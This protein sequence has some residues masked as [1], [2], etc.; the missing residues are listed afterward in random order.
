MVGA[1]ALQREG[2]F[3]QLFHN[4]KTVNIII[5][6]PVMRELLVTRLLVTLDIVP[7]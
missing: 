4:L 3:I 6:I 2:G 5:I 7:F 1:R